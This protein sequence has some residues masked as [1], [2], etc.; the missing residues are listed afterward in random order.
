MRN[1]K[2]TSIE[3][4]LKHVRKFYD[5]DFYPKLFEF[6]AIQHNWI[7]V[8]QELLKIDLDDYAPK[9]PFICLAPKKNATYRVVHQLDPIDT[10]IYTAILYEFAEK[11]ESYRIPSDKNIACSYRINP[12]IHGSF[13]GTDLDGYSKFKA[14]SLELAKQNKEGFVVVCDIT[15]FYNQIYLHRVTNVLEEAGI[16]SPKILENFLSALN[17]NISRGIPVGPAP[18]ILVSEAIMGDIDKKIISHTASFTRYVDD[19]HVYFDTFEQASFF[20]HEL[21]RYLYSNHRLVLSTEKTFID[22]NQNFIENY[23]EDEETTEQEAI[24]Q[25]LAE[26]AEAS[27]SDFYSPYGF[28]PFEIPDFEDLESGEKFTVRSEAYKDIFERTLLFEQIDFGI[29][30]HLLRKAGKYKVRSIIPLIFSNFRKLLPIIREIVVYLERI[31]NEKS[32]KK[33]KDNFQA[34]LDDEL[35]QLPFINIWIYTL[36]QNPVFNFIELKID[37]SKII[38]VREQALIAKRIKDTTWIK[39]HKDGLDVLGP[40]DKRAI[41][42]SAIILSSDEIKHW[43]GLVSSRG[44][45]LDKSVASF[46][47]SEKK[48]N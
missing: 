23:F 15:D 12:N 26:S 20:L 45:I 47:I 34:I 42:H 43:A 38:R 35:V 25:N 40:W 6:D 17:S 1:L 22:N 32:V 48:K 16:E 3:W 21:T 39:D 18:S 31:L 46:V 8:K 41:L 5:S 2:E 4:S 14:K 33:F 27:E 10:L 44:N 9:T 30:R 37:Y 7:N 28:D 29:M 11:I 19:M 24:H 13:F 36:L